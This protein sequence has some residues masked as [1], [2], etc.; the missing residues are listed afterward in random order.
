MYTI[1]GC[2]M[3]NDTG[4]P[5]SLRFCNLTHGCRKTLTNANELGFL[6]WG[7]WSLLSDDGFH[8]KIG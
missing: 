3:G 4:H 8:G 1:H 7:K 2:V 6:C 5:V